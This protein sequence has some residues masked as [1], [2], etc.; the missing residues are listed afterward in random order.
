MS[1]Q[2]NRNELLH[3]ATLGKS[4]GLKG[5]MKLHVV[6][7]FPEIFV[8]GKSF[9][10]NSGQSVSIEAVDKNLV[11]LCGID[12]PEACKPFINKKLFMT[13]KQTR[14]DCLLRHNQYFYFD[15]IGL[16]I[17]EDDQQLGIVSSIERITDIDYLLI[18]TDSKLVAKK[19]PKS[20]LMP[21]H[22]RFILHV[23]INKQIILVSGGLDILEAS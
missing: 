11:K 20:F 9:M 1:N 18:K 12:S 6:S 7:D 8:S 3:V 4:V 23:D 2:L 10:L 17:V 15:I 13:H 16:K 5:F 21:Y 14:E 22:D 19:L